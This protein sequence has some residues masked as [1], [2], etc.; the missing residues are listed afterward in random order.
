MLKQFLKLP[1]R[2]KQLIAVVADYVL[3]VFAFWPA[4]ALRF[5]TLAPSTE[6][7]PESWW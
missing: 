2:Q 5:E 7:I 1:R 3:L 4:L 6:K